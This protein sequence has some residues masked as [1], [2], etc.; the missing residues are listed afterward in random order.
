M[1]TCENDEYEIVY[2]TKNIQ[3]DNKVISHNDDHS[4]T[5]FPNCFMTKNK[6]LIVDF[7]GFNDSKGHIIGIFMQVALY[8]LIRDHSPLVILI[9]DI[10]AN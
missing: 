8:N 10:N 3:V 9:S 4:F 5:F 6:E 2:E 1:V 7:P